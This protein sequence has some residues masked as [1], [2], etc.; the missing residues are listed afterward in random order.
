MK[1]TYLIIGGCTLIVLLLAVWV[2]LLIYGTPKP[3]ENFF[4][5]FSFSGNSTTEGAVPFIPE[6]TD[7]QVD[8]GDV[9]PLRQLTTK[10]VIGFG[11]QNSNDTGSVVY[12]EAGTGHVYAINLKTGTETRL[13]NITIP[14]AQL[15][16]FSADGI[17]VAIRSG[18][19][20]QNTIELLKLN[21]ENNA[22]KETLTQKMV[23]FTFN[24]KNEL[25]YT[26]YTNDGLVGRTLTIESKTTKNLFTVPFQ[27]AT[28]VWDTTGGTN[29]YAYP[30]ASARLTGYLYSIQNG[31]LSREQAS[32]KGLVAL[33]NANYYVYSITTGN[34][35]ISYVYNRSTGEKNSLPILIQ[36]GKCTFDKNNIDRMYCGFEKDTPQYEFPDSWY[37]GLTSFSDKIYDIDIKRGLATQLSSPEDKVGRPLD[38]ADINNN[39]TGKMLYFINKNDNTL[40]MYE[41]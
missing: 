17:Y 20:T 29:H 6:V 30:K 35:P 13:S 3:V 41:I 19:G 25:L 22:T 4:T 21:G 5:D 33:S 11:E 38:I 27:S 32:G 12:A 36:P 1:K 9:S 34:R 26:E 15:A 39:S 7:S 8:V 24:Q 28:I 10:A 2:Y 37:K 14:N 31:V 40:W 16:K 23:D 18:Y